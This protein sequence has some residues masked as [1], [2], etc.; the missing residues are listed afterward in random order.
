MPDPNVYADQIVTLVRKAGAFSRFSLKGQYFGNNTVVTIEGEQ[1]TWAEKAE[2]VFVIDIEGSDDQ[3]LVVQAKCH[4]TEADPR[5]RDCLA[6][7][8]I[9]IDNGTSAITINP[10]AIYI[11]DIIS[12]DGSRFMPTIRRAK[13]N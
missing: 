2:K 10:N 1:A 4:D 9:T 7:C 5:P 13:R 3:Y 12:D 6:T 11:D 8:A